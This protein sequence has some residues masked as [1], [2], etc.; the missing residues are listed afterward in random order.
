MLIPKRKL[1]IKRYVKKYPGELLHADT[2]YLG[3]SIMQDRNRYYLFGIIDDCSRLAYVQVVT[4]IKAAEVSKV[5]F[6]S[7]GFLLAH[8]I[9]PERVMT[10]NRVEFTAFTSLKVKRTLGT[11]ASHD[12]Y[13]CRIMMSGLVFC[14]VCPSDLSCLLLTITRWLFLLLIVL[15]KYDRTALLLNV[16]SYLCLYYA[17]QFCIAVLLF[18]K[19]SCRFAVISD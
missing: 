7:L 5:F 16:S 6:H 9:Q 10:G 2:Y 12:A 8:G 1:K 4:S 18:E 14:L 17:C 15:L 3:K 13:L 11:F 19:Y